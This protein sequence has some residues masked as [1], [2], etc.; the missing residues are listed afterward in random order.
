[1]YM[2]CLI[3]DFLNLVFNANPRQKK[4]IEKTMEIFELQDYIQLEEMLS[5]YCKSF[6]MGEIVEAYSLFVE[7]TSNELKFFLQN[8]RYRY[9][10]FEE[11]N[12]SVY[13]NVEYMSK[14]MIGLA[15]SGSLWINHVRLFHWFQQI[16][17][18]CGGERYLE[19]GPGHGR[20]FC[21][22]VKK[23]KFKYYDGIDVSETSVKL[24]NRIIME[25]VGEN[26]RNRCNVF[27]QD[28]LFYYPSVQYDFI[29]IAEVLE[30][31][32]NPRLMMERIYAL[33]R[34]NSYIYLTVPV[35]APEIDH[36]Y[37]F[38]TIEEV[39]DIVISTGFEIIQCLYAPAGDMEL[40][41]AI[42]K[43]NAILVG[44]FAR[45]S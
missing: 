36:I 45:R 13:S 10:S 16:I 12:C 33:C 29:V 34:P 5:F 11:T 18:E 6:S 3:D 9:S 4:S 28:A 40:N 14:Y 22:A 42:S 32:E 1:M 44:V 38:N 19:I 15:L 39:Q 23:G 2:S 24:T 8:G 25:F 30:H 20:Y 43:K 41:K 37:L 31:L 7:E 35:N 17:E 26:T 21:E 27:C